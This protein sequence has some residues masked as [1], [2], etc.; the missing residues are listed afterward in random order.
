MA[1]NIYDVF[2]KPAEKTKTPQK[3]QL[4]KEEWAAKKQA[5]RDNAYADIAYM[6]EQVQHSPLADPTKRMF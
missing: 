1:D 2:N 4:S 3:Q 5:E 6:M